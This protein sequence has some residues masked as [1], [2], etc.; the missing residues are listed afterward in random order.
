MLFCIWDTRVADFEKFT[1][2]TGY[3][4]MGGMVTFDKGYWQNLG[5]TW[6]EPGFAQTAKSPC[7]GDRLE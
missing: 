7:R 2:S 5:N 1:E 3:N 4:A 6:K